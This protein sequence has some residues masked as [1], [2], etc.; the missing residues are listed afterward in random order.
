MKEV[1][2]DEFIS[3]DMRNGQI[4]G[5]GIIEN[6]RVTRIGNSKKILSGDGITGKSYSINQNTINIITEKLEAIKNRQKLF[7]E[8]MIKWE[9]VRKFGAPVPDNV[10]MI[11]EEDYLV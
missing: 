10:N 5:M 4:A 9:L 7:P 1:Y 6:P 3:T 8:K 2:P 11:N